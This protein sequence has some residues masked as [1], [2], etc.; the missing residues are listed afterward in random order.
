MTFDNIKW[1]MA[2]GHV[3]TLPF[4]I[5]CREFSILFPKR[6][7]AT[8]VSLKWEMQLPAIH[9]LGSQAEIVMMQLFEKSLLSLIEKDKHGILSIVY[10]SKNIREYTFHTKDHKEFLQ[11]LVHIPQPAQKYPVQ[12]QSFDDENWL[13]DTQLFSYLGL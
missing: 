6:V 5:R 2:E 13:Y 1:T 11:R 12:I 10:T 7:Y 3:K 9:G 4:K 8:R